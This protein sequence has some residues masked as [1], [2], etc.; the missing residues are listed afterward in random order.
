MSE[1]YIEVTLIRSVQSN[2]VLDKVLNSVNTYLLRNKGAVSDFN[3]IKDVVERNT[4]AV[5]E[6][7]NALLPIPLYLGLMGT[8]I[9]IVIGLFSMPSISDANFESAIDM[10]IGGVKIAMIAS[11][12]GLLLTVILSGYKYKSAKLHA[13]GLKNDLFS[14][15]QTQL[16]PVLS[17]NI[18]SSIYALQANLL[19][20]NDTFSTNISSFN[21]LMNK[22]LESFNSQ[23]SLMN[24]LKEVDVAQLAKLNVNVLQELRISTK[25]FEKF[26]QFLSQLNVFV[27]NADKLNYNITNQ[28]D[29]TQA[30]ETIA[31]AMDSNI[32]VNKE[33]MGVLQ[34]EM[35]E[36]ST[37][38]K[39]VTDTV[40]DVDNTLTQ[41]L[42]QLKMHI[43]AQ[44]TAIK[45]I[46]IKEEDLLE[47]LLME[48]RGNL[49]ELKKLSTL[50][51]GMSSLEKET[52]SHNDK[53]DTLNKAIENL[54]GQ[55]AKPSEPAIKIPKAVQYAGYVFI[56]T[57]AI[58]GLGFCCWTLYKMIA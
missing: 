9:G 54:A 40:I 11:F 23:V 10:L 18:S 17:Q 31:N 12:I 57:G 49:N 13:E 21:G 29:R 50:N 3:L 20:F 35:R 16:L 58:V 25:E 4:D 15:I 22:I 56:G 7:I 43:D 36:F 34:M 1:K 30:V 37:R 14:W 5:D 48:D 44:I 51:T 27:A 52:K 28:L 55:L 46:T 42:D 24:E 38:K 19:K 26:T 53:L 32:Q 45:N 41:S 8:M 6:E 47:K 2:P 39:M 33:L